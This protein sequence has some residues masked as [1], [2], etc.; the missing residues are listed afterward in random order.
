MRRKINKITIQLAVNIF[1]DRKRYIADCPPLQLS[2][3]GSS[4]SEV[5][6]HFEEALKLWLETTIERDT[7][8]KALIELGW[9]IKPYIAPKEI[10]YKGENIN[11][12]KQKYYPINIPVN[13]C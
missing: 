2:T 5:Q 13:A 6:R 10:D 9:K 1:K 4:I 12:L 8:E 11:L 7:L 3:H